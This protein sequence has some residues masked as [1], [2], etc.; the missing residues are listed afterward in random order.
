VAYQRTFRDKHGKLKVCRT[1]TVDVRI[2]DEIEEI[3]TGMRDKGAAEE[4]GRK[5]Q[6]L[7]NLRAAG[8]EPNADLSRWCE[9]LSNKLK[10]KLAGLGL[11]TGRA[12]AARR[13]LSEHLDEY[14]Q[15]IIDGAASP[16]QKGPSTLHH[17][18]TVKYRVQRILDGIGATMLSDVHP[19]DVGRWIAEQ[20]A[21]KMSARSAHNYL[22]SGKAFFAWM[23]RSKRATENP[24]ACLSKPQVTPKLRK[25]VRRSL[26]IDEAM[27][28]L[29]VTKAGPVCCRMTG[30]DRY[31]L[32]RV[33]LETALRA[34]ELR[35]LTPES[36]HLDDDEPSVYLPGDDTKNRQDAELPL[37]PKT[38]RDIRPYLQ[39]K[40]PG[41]AV[42]QMPIPATTVRLLKFDL[43]AAKI[44][45]ADDAGRVVDFHSLRVSAITWMAASGA[46]VKVLQQFARHSDASLTLGTYTK[47]L[48]GGL[49]DAASKV[50]SLS[51]HATAE[52]T[53]AKKEA[54]N[55]APV[56]DEK[57]VGKT[58]GKPVP[59]GA[60]LCLIDDDQDGTNR[61]KTTGMGGFRHRSAVGSELCQTISIASP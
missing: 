12:A 41:V 38:V 28:L 22:T 6:R 43:A 36:F 58:V 52:H 14:R 40:T 39:D 59:Q 33:A 56:A 4:M 61:R 25:H 15:A 31:W 42:F 23:I 3:S 21:K 34:G 44:P 50:P 2:G 54:T 5:I 8:D 29:R 17:A 18:N 27:E 37:K 10:D 35:T 55:D 48:A 30:L 49:A 60:S 47:V 24:L 53:E 16:R 57:T 51:D 20:R 11:L 9:G 13:R 7:A 32:Y 19:E 45:Y 1:H 26:E 46:T